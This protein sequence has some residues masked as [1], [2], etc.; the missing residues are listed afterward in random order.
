MVLG[1]GFL[2]ATAAPTLA[3][4]K[5]QPDI[6]FKFSPMLQIAGPLA[7]SAGLALDFGVAK[8]ASVGLMLGGGYESV[9]G[10]NT[11]RLGLGF[12][13]LGYVFPIIARAGGP[14]INTQGFE[15]YLGFQGGYY[16]TIIGF[17]DNEPLV[18]GASR[19][20][21]VLGTRWYPGNKRGFGLLAEVG[22]VGPVGGSGFMLGIT[23]GR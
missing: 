5:G 14:S 17:G 13:T 22:S 11:A 20:G 21:L 19:V 2:W 10:L 18:V 4:D 15:P 23:L 6:K 9:L 3:Q 8:V 16:S 1:L 7:P 12:R